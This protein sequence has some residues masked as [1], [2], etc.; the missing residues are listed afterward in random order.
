MG[1]LLRSNWLVDVAMKLGIRLN[2]TQESTF[3]RPALR[4]KSCFQLS[5]E[6]PTDGSSVIFDYSVYYEKKLKNAYYW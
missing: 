5:N 3:A 6:R 4:K 2:D 1:A